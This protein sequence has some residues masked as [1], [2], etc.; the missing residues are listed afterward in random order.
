M[1]TYVKESRES[2]E[3]RAAAKTSF[4]LGLTA[5]IL[6]LL[7]FCLQFFS[8]VVS[9]IPGI[10]IISFVFSLFG[11]WIYIIAIIFAGVAKGKAKKG[12]GYP[13]AKQGNNFATVGLVFSIIGLVLN[14]LIA[15]AIACLIGLILGVGIIGIIIMIIIALVT[16][17][18]ISEMGAGIALLALL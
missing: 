11:I 2:L 4:G 14:I 10:G 15:V 9:W 13:K 8:S 6:G 5:F 17:S 7:M 3:K 18:T 16:S 1:V 12:K